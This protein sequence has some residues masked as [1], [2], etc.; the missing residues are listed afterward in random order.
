MYDLLLKGGHLVDP[1]TKK[2]GRFDVAISGG[3]VSRVAPE[4]PRSEAAEVL[5][6]SDKLVIPGLVDLHVHASMEYR[7]AHRML[8]LA[9]VTT[10]LD[11][12]GPIDEVMTVGREYGAGI[13]M[14]CVNRV[15]AGEMVPTVDPSAAE[16][17]QG[18]ADVMDRGALGVKILGGHFPLTPE[19]SGRVFDVA[20][21]L[22]AWVAIHCGS[23]ANGSNLN[24]LKEALSLVGENHLHIAHI[25][26]YCR[27]AVKEPTLEALEVIELLKG[28]D[29]LVTE[30]YLAVINGT[31]AKCVNGRVESDLTRSCLRKGGYGDSVDEVRRAVLEGFCR[32]CVTE[33]DRTLLRTGPEAV[34]VWEA[35]GTHV[36]ASFPVNPP[37]PRLMLAQAKDDQGRFVVD[38][39]GTDGGGFPRN[40]TVAF[41]LRLVELEVLTLSDFVRKACT[42]PARILGLPQ[43]GQLGEGA[44]ADIAVLDRT[45][46]TVCTTISAG[47]IVAHHG[48]IT[49]RGT[50]QIT[51]ERGR[52]AVEA[53]GLQ[54]VVVKL[55][56][57]GFYNR[58]LI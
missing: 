37:M 31:P 40:F 19:A 5:D 9:G 1:A 7:M 32:I 6:V 17:K 13:N 21:Q 52:R 30:S 22:T 53:A 43:K 54:P 33:G 11:M 56:E 41:G 27:G 23:T 15:K 29:R 50:Y 49:G 36:G 34:A 2:D 24:G 39:L 42:T 55:E 58:N 4:I 8:A 48:V 16:L 46:A 51:T 25:N 44:D 12:A 26:S 28:R 3:R 45:S 47:K 20:N 35:A 14:A 10:A 18:I 38:A 57:S